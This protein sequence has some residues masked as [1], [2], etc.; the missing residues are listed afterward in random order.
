MAVLAGVKSRNKLLEMAF[1]AGKL[2]AHIATRKLPNQAGVTVVRGDFL[3]VG[4]LTEC[5]G[6]IRI[7]IF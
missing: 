2:R 5:D 7:A 1:P 3:V 4:Y 6:E